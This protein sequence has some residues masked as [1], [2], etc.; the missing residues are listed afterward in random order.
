[1]I[2]TKKYYNI[3][4][5]TIQ[6]LIK[7][8]NSYRYICEYLKD[9]H[10]EFNIQEYNSLF[11]IGKNIVVEINNNSTESILVSAHYDDNG[12][13]D[14]CGG[15]L[16]LLL[17]CQELSFLNNSFCNYVLIFTDQEECFQQGIYYYIKNN[18]KTKFKY[19]LNI[20]GLGIGK[21]LIL[22][23]S[24][25]AHIV[26]DWLNNQEKVI[27][28]TDN[29]PFTS[30]NI[31]SLHLFS[32]FESEASEITRTQNLHKGFQNY[33]NEEWCKLNFDIEFFED[34]YSSKI[35]NLL[36]VCKDD[37][38]LSSKFTIL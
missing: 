32:C 38:S 30:F 24:L 20:D 33:F 10:V 15:V 3:A 34:V 28:L 25:D 21:E 29:S 9:R 11:G 17:L 16:Q 36:V 37:Y 23:N 22:F 35:L 18:I 12:I 19:H 5:D 14:N 2:A 27:L 26:V 6:E 1:M 31:D 8:N 13:Y 7:T 4:Q